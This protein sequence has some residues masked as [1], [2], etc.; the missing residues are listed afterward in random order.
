MFSLVNIKVLLYYLVTGRDYNMK[1]KRGLKVGVNL[2]LGSNCFIDPVHCWLITI[3]NNVVL[4]ANVQI[5]AH[6][7][8]TYKPLKLT[9]L[10]KLP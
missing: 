8:S 5:F 10:G 2:F 9:K 1:E 6:D 7:A 3:G 4:A